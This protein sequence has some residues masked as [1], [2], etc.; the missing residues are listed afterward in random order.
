V[1]HSAS[2]LGRL[3]RPKAVSFFGIFL[4][5]CTI[6]TPL[7]PSSTLPLIFV[8]SFLLLSL[9]LFNSLRGQSLALR[10]E[11]VDYLLLLSAFSSLINSGH[12]VLNVN[13]L[14]AEFSVVILYYFVPVV[15][16]E[17]VVKKFSA[18]D[19]LRILKFCCSI[20]FV[21]GVADYVAGIGGVDL[22]KALGFEA[23]RLAGG[24]YLVRSRGFFIE[25][26]DYGLALNTFFPLTIA[27]LASQEKGI[28]P[29]AYLLAYIFL[30]IIARSTAAIIGVVLGFAI[31]L[32]VLKVRVISGKRMILTLMV[33]G[34]L[35][36]PLLGVLSEVLTTVLMKA[37]FSGESRSAAGRSAAYLTYLNYFDFN[38]LKYFLGEGTGFVS[39]SGLLG[40]LSWLLS[41]YVEKGIIGLAIIFGISLF[42][43][44][45][46]YRLQSHIVSVGLLTTYI[47]T[48]VHLAT[49]TG[50]Y[51]P[52][53]WIA[54]LFIR[55]DWRML[56]NLN[57]I[58]AVG[59]Q[60]K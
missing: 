29:L 17:N 19:L 47:A 37:S 20:L 15:Y 25:P 54:L 10:R 27:L 31:S 11:R 38:S 48:L 22:S 52:F 35:C 41:V 43:F 28:K 7:N 39:G 12:N 55:L 8:Q 4:L 26:S 49:Q 50:F 32:I 21:T 45:R 60:N 2:M 58:L 59:N 5:L 51:L 30:M 18:Q 13:H 57:P 36:I 9:V 53:F 24:G 33:L 46:I 42:A 14:I 23:N 16:L 1:N 3:L 56:L 34:T 6:W 44:F 40:T